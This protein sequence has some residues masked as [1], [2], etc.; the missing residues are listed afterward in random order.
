LPVGGM[1]PVPMGGIRNAG[2]IAAREM[3]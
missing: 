1:A 2:A 3:T